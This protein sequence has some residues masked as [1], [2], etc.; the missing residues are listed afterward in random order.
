MSLEDTHDKNM[1]LTALI[2][3]L[4]YR[5][6]HIGLLNLPTP[7]STSSPLSLSSSFLLCVCTIKYINVLVYSKYGC[8]HVYG[9]YDS[10][11]S[12]TTRN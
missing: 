11:H 1:R 2:I 3:F 8:A 6:T 7:S 12:K 5:I 10:V 4:P 9:K